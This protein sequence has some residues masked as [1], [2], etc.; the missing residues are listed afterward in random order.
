MKALILLWIVI[1]TLFGIA[2]RL[3]VAVLLIGL[4][5]GGLLVKL[6]HQSLPSFDAKGWSPRF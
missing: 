5:F 6:A 4:A 2:W 1:S 3:T